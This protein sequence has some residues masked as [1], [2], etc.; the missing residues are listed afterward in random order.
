[1]RYS[2]HTSHSGAL[3]VVQ[4]HIFRCS[5]LETLT[6]RHLYAAGAVAFYMLCFKTLP[7]L[8]AFILSY[9]VFIGAITYL[10]VASINSSQFGSQPPCNTYLVSGPFR[11]P[12]GALLFALAAGPWIFAIVGMV[13]WKVREVCARAGATSITGP[14]EYEM[15]EVEARLTGNDAELASRA[16]TSWRN[17]MCV[18]SALAA[19]RMTYY[20]SLPVLHGQDNIGTCKYGLW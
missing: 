16:I 20:A 19:Y 17:L 5:L 1:M 12:G 6:I 11:I 14:E 18:S 3:R 15:Q 7:Q 10:T 8:G 9:A 2:L 4:S 13:L